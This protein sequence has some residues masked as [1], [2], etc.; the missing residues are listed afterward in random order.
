LG[1]N[2]GIRHQHRCAATGKSSAAPE[3]KGER[4]DF[5][6]RP[7]WFL[8]RLLAAVEAFRAP[9]FQG[10]YIDGSF[11][12][13]KRS[14]TI[15]T[16]IGWSSHRSVLERFRIYHG[17][18]RSDVKV[19]MW[20]DLG[21]ESFICANWRRLSRR[22]SRSPNPTAVILRSLWPESGLPR[23]T[24]P[25]REKLLRQAALAHVPLS[26]VFNAMRLWK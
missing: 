17:A 11:G 25:L 21:I 5:A 7:Q 22:S 1:I 8:K 4:P 19:A 16:A 18:A 24:S 9:Q 15:T 3:E 10:V 2:S 12:S 20:D 13:E 26:L 23:S 14:P 6:P